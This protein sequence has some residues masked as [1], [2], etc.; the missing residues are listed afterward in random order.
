MRICAD[1]L[2]RSQSIVTHNLQEVEL[3]PHEGVHP[4]PNLV[5]DLG[6]LLRANHVDVVALRLVAALV[7]VAPNVCNVEVEM[8]KSNLGQLCTQV[9]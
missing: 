7:F 1:P 6:P 8:L 2:K 4:E 5:L 3:L 9:D